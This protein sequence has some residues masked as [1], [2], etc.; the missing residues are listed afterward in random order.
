MSRNTGPKH[1]MCRRVGQPLCGLP[2]CPAL[3]RPYPPGQHG[4]RP[5]R[6]ESEYGKQLLEK[7]KL[8]FV[9]GVAERQFRRYFDQ[10]RRGS[11]RPGDR[12]LQ[13]LETRLDN[14]VYRLGF[15]RTLHQARQLVTH[16]HIMLNDRKVDIP[17]HQVNP[18]DTVTF[19][20]K[21]RNLDIVKAAIE[22]QSEL[23]PYLER[24]VEARSG[25]LIRL[26]ERE[27]IPVPVEVELI[28]EFY[29]R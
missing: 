8:R 3:K 26:P 1:R 18:G 28:V 29:S 27:E 4:Q 24:D 17:S 6:R 2:N 7:Q 19:R 15:A 22:S 20:E 14:V 10:A 21:S 25:R 13:L 12:L 16:G 9:Y 11:G 23:P 5:R